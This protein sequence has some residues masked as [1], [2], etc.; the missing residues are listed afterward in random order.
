VTQQD[1]CTQCSG[2]QHTSMQHR[3]IRTTRKGF[4]LQAVSASCV[5]CTARD[6]KHLFTYSHCSDRSS[7]QC[8]VRHASLKR[9]YDKLL[10][11]QLYQMH[12][13]YA[14]LKHLLRTN[15]SYDTTCSAEPA[16]YCS[17]RLHMQIKARYCCC[18]CILQ[19]SQSCGLSVFQ[20][21]VS[22]LLGS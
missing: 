6:G 10:G 14:H 13:L 21:C 15:S 17:A 22:S 7:K 1:A 2:V 8:C 16:I 19:H 11:I 9:A 18:V 20:V 12:Q 5:A 3:R 4:T